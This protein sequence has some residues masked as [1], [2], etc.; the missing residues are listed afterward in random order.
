M[1]SRPGTASRRARS[2]GRARRPRARGK[3][4]STAAWRS[5]GV[6]P[7]VRQIRPEQSDRRRAGDGRRI[8]VPV[9]RRAPAR[10]SAGCELLQRAAAGVAEHQIEARRGR[11]AEVAATSSP[12]VEAGQGHRRVEVVEHRARARGASSEHRARAARASGQNDVTIAGVR[13]D[14]A[15]RRGGSA[16]RP[17]SG[18]GAARPRAGSAGRGARRSTARRARRTRPGARGRR[19]PASPATESRVRSPRR[20]DREPE[21]DEF[22]RRMRRPVVSSRWS[23]RGALVQGR[24]HVRHQGCSSAAQHGS[25]RSTSR[26][27]ITEL[28]E[29]FHNLE[30]RGVRPRPTTSSA[31][32]PRIK[33][34]ALR[35]RAARRPA[36]DDVLDIGCNAGFYSLEMKRRGAAR[37]LGIDWDERYLAQAR[38]AAEICGVDDRDQKLSVYDVARARRALRRRAVHGR[39]LPP[40]P[41]AA[42]ARPAARARRPR[43]AGLPEHAC[44]APTTVDAR[45]APTTRSPSA[46]SSSSPAIRSCTSSSSDTRAIRPTGGSPT[47]RAPRRCCAASGYAI[48][49]APRRRG[50]VCRR[51]SL[52]ARDPGRLPRRGGAP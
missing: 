13:I 33:W 3:A 10:A 39:A 28:G 25:P 26:S 32:T 17:R 38:F 2:D 27:R 22:H 45:R 40:A 8:D 35:A 31:T 20:T 23:L 7:Q 21:D 47:A 12:A 9:E 15:R 36:R 16:S 50:L 42:R 18:T 37:V 46:R 4:R 44:A 11:R 14:A 24:G 6:G 48:D 49:R 19:A 1:G 51:P 5:V 52:P 43:S 34:R 29:W 41:S 30:L